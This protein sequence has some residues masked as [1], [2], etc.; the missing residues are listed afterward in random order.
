M[1][2]MSLI[3]LAF[4][5]VETDSSPKHVA[6]LQI[7][8]KPS[9]AGRDYLDRL[10]Q[11]WLTSSVSRPFNQVPAYRLGQLPHW[12]DVP[13]FNLN[14]HIFRHHLRAPGGRLQLTNL[15]GELHSIR[16]KTYRPPWECHLLE[17]LAGERFAVY[18]KIH[19]AYGDGHRINGWL[20]RP[21]SR[22]KR[23]FPKFAYW[24]TPDGSEQGVEVGPLSELRQQLAAVPGIS[25]MGLRQALKWL[26]VGRNGAA[27]PFSAPRT[28]LN[29]HLGPSRAVAL[30]RFPLARLR[31][32]GQPHGCTVNDV[33]LT[34]CSRALTAYLARRGHLPTQPLVAQVPVSLRSDSEQE[35]AGN[36]VTLAL[37]TL[38]DQYTDPIEQMLAVHRACNDAK[39]EVHGISPM[40]MKGYTNLLAGS[41]LLAEAVGLG[42]SLPPLGN[43][44][45]SNVPG[46]PHRHYMGSATL[47]EA[48]PVST[49]MPSVALNITVYSY[50]GSLFVGMVCDR[51]VLRDLPRLASLMRRAYQEIASAV[52]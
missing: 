4:L 1:T 14:D 50:A 25:A 22:R 49:L 37:V 38:A 44:L 46:D 30:L 34:L 19:H 36:R 27:P 42:M 26:G 13:N 45:I 35:S 11:I 32:L 8:R 9:A 51:E 15:V 7:F 28:V 20:G 16:L 29:A 52:T 17:G 5:L 3:D 24:Q 21:L 2:V 12:E 41:V 10:R 31:Q 39:A 40:A 6:G 47:L 33:V 48:Y 23:E 43:V 18:F